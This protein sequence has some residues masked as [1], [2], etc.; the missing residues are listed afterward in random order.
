M[1]G[2]G[3]APADVGKFYLNEMRAR[4]MTI[5][6]IAFAVPLLILSDRSLAVEDRR[7]EH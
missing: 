7:E 5:F 1:D 2:R 3:D 6:D 4:G